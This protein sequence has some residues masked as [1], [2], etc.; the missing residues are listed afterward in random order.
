MW[1]GCLF[2]IVSIGDKA[3]QLLGKVI[4]FTTKGGCAVGFITSMKDGSHRLQAYMSPAAAWAFSIG[5]S[6]GWGS[7][8]IT[9]NDYLLSAGPAG[10]CLGMLVGMVV[11]LVIAGNYSYLMNRY[12]SAGGVYTYSKQAF[13][14]D[15]GFLTAWFIGMTYMAILW[16]NATSVP[17]FAQYFF[18]DAFKVGLHYVI[19]GYDIYLGEV[20]LSVVAVL[21]FGLL[22][23]GLKRFA[24]RLMVGLAAAFTLGITVCFGVS[25]GGLEGGMTSFD[26]AFIP[27]GNELSQVI[28]I[29]CIS[30]WAFIG[31]E[32][33]SHM[34]EEFKF[35]HSK[36]FRVLAVSVASTTALYLFVILLSTTA[37][38]PQ[39]ENWFDYI[40]HLDDMQGIEG[41]PAFYAAYHYLGDTGVNLL[42]IALFA[43]IAT[44]LI[45]NITALS[46]LMYALAK[47]DVLPRGLATLSGQGTPYRAILAIVV[48][49]CIIPL[50]GRTAIGWIV[51]VTTIGATIT[52]GFVSASAWKTAQ[53]HGDQKH[54]TLGIVGLVLMIIMGAI[55]I[56]PNLF[57]KSTMATE[58]Y[59]LFTVWAVLG[60][61]FFRKIMRTDPDNRFGE[62]V[63]VWIVLLAFVMFMSCV[64]M[65]E[66]S[67]RAAG[68]ALANM[69]AYYEEHAGTSGTTH[70]EKA[71]YEQQLSALHVTNTTNTLMILAIFAISLGVLINNFSFMRKR[72]RESVLLLGLERMRANVDELTG[73]GN[74]YAYIEARRD[75]DARISQGLPTSFAIAACDLNNLKLIND[76]M[77]H[78]A[79]D[80]YIA[81]AGK[82]IEGVYAHSHVYRIGCDEFAVIIEGEDY[83]QRVELTDALRARSEENVKAGG[84]V[85]SVGLAEYEPGHDEGTA[86]V[87]NRADRLMYEHKRELKVRMAPLLEEG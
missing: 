84:V 43:L 42:F 39:F 71:Y 24:A 47:D 37:H 28:T 33:I 48:I 69:Q 32:N 68:D 74:R 11:M 20:L 19:F 70:E 86:P 38:P 8:V 81:D 27:N 7:F 67:E 5:T 87:F 49:S 79:G 60:L 14:Y 9:S 62:S 83:P 1:R 58:S 13:G 55:L 52:Y 34:S 41:L 51:D 30:P 2:S 21:V 65:E 45:G 44:S 54:S 82:L 64:W 3:P 57:A 61:L 73:L 29:A 25:L 50:L 23:M 4:R 46:R 35:S 72:E 56:V 40:S 16:A 85:I 31:F 77:G 15:H 18:G 10:S 6:I 76:V 12:P 22:C 80:I 53:L 66:S 75:I 78:S 26:P 17:L 63:I 59:F 36:S